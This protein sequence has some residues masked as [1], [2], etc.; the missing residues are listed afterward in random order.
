MA[1]TGNLEN[2]TNPLFNMMGGAPQQ[3]P[4]RGAPPTKEMQDLLNKYSHEEIMEMYKQVMSGQVPQNMS[5]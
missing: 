2:P 3:P 1:S 5:M 4:P